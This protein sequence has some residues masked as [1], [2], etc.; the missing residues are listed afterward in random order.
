MLVPGHISGSRL[1][2]R[3]FLP[4]L[5]IAPMQQCRSLPA[6]VMLWFPLPRGAGW[7]GEQLR[8]LK[9]TWC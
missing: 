5:I 7:L 2:T 1:S 8:L 4:T 9:I 6:L 3:A